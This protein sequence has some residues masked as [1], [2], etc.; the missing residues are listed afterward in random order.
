MKKLKEYI[1]N[2]NNFYVAIVDKKVVGFIIFRRE[3]TWYGGKIMVEEL[4][5][6]NKF[7]RQGIGR[8]LLK[9]TRQVYKNKATKVVLISGRKSFAYRFY[10]KLGFRDDKD[11]AYMNKKLKS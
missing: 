6:H 2:K 8:A 5:V 3:Y 9:K 11:V 4:F 1:K 10:K 7:Q